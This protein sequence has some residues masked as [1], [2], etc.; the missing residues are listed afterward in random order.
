MDKNKNEKIDIRVTKEQKEYIKNKANELGYHSV[1][2]FLVTSAKEHFVVQIDMSIYREVA[3]EI[4]YIGKNINNLVRRINTDG[5]YK[6]TDIDHININQKKI[7]QLMNKEYGR[8]LKQKKKYLSGDLALKDKQVLLDNFKKENIKIPRSILL[9]EVYEK[10]KKD[11][12]YICGIIESSPS[13]E[14][15]LHDYIWEYV[16]KGRT[17]YELKNEQLIEFANDLFMYTQKLQFKMA[18]FSNEFN[19]DDWYELKDILD[20]YEI[21]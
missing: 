11:V 16:Y 17:L 9:E 15:G 1:T 5:F 7:I 13:K 12:I 2:A 6:D 21:Y 8:L 18:E 4:N 3:N 19:D 20:E 10:I 14:E